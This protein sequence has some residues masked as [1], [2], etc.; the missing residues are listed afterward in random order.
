MKK[1][2]RLLLVM[3]MVF[4]VF[5]PINANA[6]EITRKL[7]ELDGY[8]VEYNIAESWAN[9]QNITVTIENTGSESNDKRI[10]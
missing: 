6:E 9:N 7:Y 3:V 5:L 10:F 2:C 4:S 8:T 1:T